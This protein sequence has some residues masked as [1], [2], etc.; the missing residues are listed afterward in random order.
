MF[1]SA[2]PHGLS[3]L[4]RVE[5]QH[6]QNPFRVLRYVEAFKCSDKEDGQEQLSEKHTSV[7]ESGTL[8]R[9]SLVFQ[10]PSLSRTTSQSSSSHRGWEILRR[11][12][13]GPLSLGQDLGEGDGEEIYHFW[14]ESPLWLTWI[15]TWSR[16]G[17]WGRCLHMQVSY[18]HSC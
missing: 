4:I 3:L 10:T 1:T 15:L 11:N 16:W 18:F 6:D 2:S 8:A 7:A 17:K 13:L 14:W 5:N 12:T 9:A